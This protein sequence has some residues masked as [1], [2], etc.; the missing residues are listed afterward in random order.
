MNNHIN[1]KFIFHITVHKISLIIYNIKISLS[2]I[3]IVL[4]NSINN[5]K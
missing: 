1:P 5:I 2:N 4:N 3:N